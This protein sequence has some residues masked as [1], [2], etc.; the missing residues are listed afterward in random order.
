MLVETMGRIERDAFRAK[1]KEEWCSL[2]RERFD[3]RIRAEGVSVREYPTLFV[4]RGHVIFASRRAKTPS[5]S[6]IVE[7]WSSQNMVYSPD[8]SGGGWGKFIRTEVRKLGH[9]RTRVFEDNPS[10]HKSK[11][12]QLRKGGRGWLHVE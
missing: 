11:K 9:S 6:E 3:D 4:D 7:Y 12:K 1:L 2:W 10:E 5:F 8:P